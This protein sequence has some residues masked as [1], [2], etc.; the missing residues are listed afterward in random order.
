MKWKSLWSRSDRPSITRRSWMRRTS[1]QSLYL[2][3][4]VHKHVLFIYVPS[5]TLTQQ[6]VL[7]VSVEPR[8]AV[9][10]WR[11]AVCAGDGDRR[12]RH[13][14]HQSVLHAS[15]TEAELCRGRADSTGDTVSDRYSK[16]FTRQFNL[17]WVYGGQHGDWNMVAKPK[18]VYQVSLGPNS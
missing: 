5:P 6:N 18:M 3:R 16:P 1:Q 15:A 10:G 8:R 2:L 13:A 4:C 12:S 9:C 17:M 11:E 14:L 7:T